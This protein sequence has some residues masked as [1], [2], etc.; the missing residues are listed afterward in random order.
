MAEC[1]NCRTEYDHH[2]EK[3]DDIRNQ[4]HIIEGCSNCGHSEQWVE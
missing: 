4:I 2:E 1:P 3:Y